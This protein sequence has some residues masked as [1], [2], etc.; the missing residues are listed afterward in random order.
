MIK[1]H[2]SILRKI[3]ENLLVKNPNIAGNIKPL[4]VVSVIYKTSS[5]EDR[6][7]RDAIV[8]SVKRLSIKVAIINPNDKTK[9]MVRTFF[10]HSPLIKSIVVDRSPRKSS[11][12]K[13]YYILTK[14]T[15]AIKK[16]IN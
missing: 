1:F 16:A 14:N 5:N 4:C 12:A 9:T 3:E 7:I 6:V 10:L 13:P 15:G 11:K 8:I 2:M